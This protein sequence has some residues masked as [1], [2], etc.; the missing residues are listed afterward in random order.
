M[1]RTGRLRIAGAVITQHSAENTASCQ[2]KDGGLDV[3]EAAEGS[4]SSGGYNGGGGSASAG[5]LGAL[6]EARCG[7]VVRMRDVTL[8][9][10]PPRCT[11]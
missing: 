5:A 2:G 11:F 10:T 1:G 4:A 6:E 3:D 7:Q 9:L 8:A